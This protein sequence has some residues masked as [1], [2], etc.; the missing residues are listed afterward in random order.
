VQAQNIH[1]NISLVPPLNFIGVKSAKFG[2]LEYNL[3][4]GPH[5]LHQSDIECMEKVQRRF[6]KRL[7]GLKHL[8]YGQRLKQVSL[9]SLELRRLHADLIV[10]YKILFG[11]VKLSYSDFFTLSSVT[12][13]RGHRYKLYIKRSHGLR[14]HFFAERIVAPWNRLPAEVLDFGS[15]NR[16]K[17][18]IK[19]VDLSKFLTVD[20]DT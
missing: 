9:P 17:R 15:L 8:T 18:S 16:F 3:S 7:P 10:C 12:V 11:L 5:R 2:I 13:T 20:I 19:L 6:T 14:K 1:S 4:S